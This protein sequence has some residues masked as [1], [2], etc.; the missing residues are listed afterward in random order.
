M[1]DLNEPLPLKSKGQNGADHHSG[2]TSVPS[3][4]SLTIF[5]NVLLP[6][7]GGGTIQFLTPCQFWSKASTAYVPG[8]QCLLLKIWHLLFKFDEKQSTS[9]CP[10]ALLKWS[11]TQLLILQSSAG[12]DLLRKSAFSLRFLGNHSGFRVISLLSQNSFTFKAKLWRSVFF[13][14]LSSKLTWHFYYLNIP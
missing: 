12:A 9:C 7:D 8:T 2:K 4:V 1:K 10:H 11:K 3:A 5:F 6:R 14:Y 13:Y